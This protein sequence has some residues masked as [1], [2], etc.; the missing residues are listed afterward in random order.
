[1]KIIEFPSRDKS[2]EDSDPDQFLYQR[3]WEEL[4]NGYFDRR[5]LTKIESI[6]YDDDEVID[7]YIAVRVDQMK[8][9][10]VVFPVGLGSDNEELPVSNYK[11][12][13]REMTSDWKPYDFVL[14]P[15]GW[16]YFFYVIW[17]L[18]FD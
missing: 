15:L 5:L 10:H 18:V 1:M 9:N 4:K 8:R 13:W 6:A 16:G 11:L 17:D 2:G 14:A 7:M 3:A 12:F